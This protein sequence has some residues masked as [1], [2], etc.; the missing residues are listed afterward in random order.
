MRKAYVLAAVVT[1]LLTTQVATSDD[2]GELT[3]EATIGF[4]RGTD[5][6]LEGDLAF[7]SSQASDGSGGL[8]IIDISNPYDP[9]LLGHLACPGSQ[10]DVAIAGDIAILGMHQAFEAPGCTDHPRG[11]LR[12]VDVSDPTEPAEISFL[13]IP[14]S[15]VHTLTVVGDTGLVYASPGGIGL[16]V[17]D[18]ETTIIDISDPLNPTIVGTFLPPGT[19]GCHDVTVVGDRAYCAAADATQIWDI[20]DPVAPVVITAIVNPAIFFHHGAVPNADQTLLVI[21]DEAFAA[22]I[23]EPGGRSTTGAFWVYDIT[24]EQAPIL[25]SYSSQMEMTSIEHIDSRWCTAHN[26]NFLP[27]RD[28]MVAASYTGGTSLIDLSDPLRPT[29][30][31]VLR[32]ANVVTWS[33]YYHD[34]FI[35]TGDRVRGFDVIS[36]AGVSPA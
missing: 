36:I 33:S 28:W 16:S 15:G 6:V 24:I 20:S 14:N 27:D 7:V 11:G 8:R 19:T 22:H 9:S 30:L 26:F 17:R 21:A 25:M 32:P 35:Y 31:D 2:P 12:L 3:L 34:G 5:L 1:T 4:P 10:N 23:C 29:L 13:H 18:L